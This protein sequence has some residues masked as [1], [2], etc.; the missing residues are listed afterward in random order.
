MRYIVFYFSIIWMVVTASLSRAQLDFTNY[1]P[2]VSEGKIPLDFS[3]E[4]YKKIKQELSAGKDNL[5][6]REAEAFLKEIHY[7]VYH[8]LH[9][10]RVIYG[11]T[12]SR[13]IQAIANHLLQDNDSLRNKLRF[14]TLKASEANAFSTE[15]GIIF[16]TTGL[17]S[18][19]VNEAQ[20]AFVLAHEI[21]H[22]TENHSVEFYQYKLEHKK[23]RLAVK[24]FCNYSKENELEA[25][26]LGMEMYQAAGYTQ[27]ELLG[28]L[29]VLTYSYLP[30]DEV[31]V[32][33]TYFN[34]TYL[35]I[36]ISRFP[37]KKFDI[38]AIEDDNDTRS[39]HPNVKKRKEQLLEEM[40]LDSVWRNNLTFFGETRFSEVQ[41]IC[42]FETVRV[43]LLEN[44]NVDALYSIFLLEK[45][46]P[47][48]V[49]LQHMKAQVWL[50][51]LGRSMNGYSVD[52]LKDDFGYEESLEGEIAQMYDFFNR[53]PTE[54]L[55]TLGIRELYDFTKKYPGDKLFASVFTLGVKKIAFQDKFVLVNYARKPL[56][57]IRLEQ[58]KL[59]EQ[60]SKP[61]LESKKKSKYERIKNKRNVEKIENYDS[62]KY[63][64]Y[65]IPDIVSDS[66]FKQ[67]YSDF[68][69]E[70]QGKDLSGDEFFGEVSYNEN[71][72]V[73]AQ[74]QT[75]SDLNL[76]IDNAI[77]VEP[78]IVCY[79]ENHSERNY[80][81]VKGEKLN[82]VLCLEALASANMVGFNLSIIDQ[83]S[84]QKKGTSDFND[85]NVLLSF[86]Q[87]DG[88]G[89]YL[90]PVD[91]DQ[92]EDIKLR[93][94]STKIM[95]SYIESKTKYS[96]K[97][98]LTR[99]LIPYRIPFLG[100]NLIS[101][102]DG[103]TSSIMH[104]V[105]IDLEDMRKNINWEY[106]FSGKLTKTKLG[107]IYYNVLSNLKKEK[108]Q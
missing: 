74:K 92:L 18:Q 97:R 79:A 19:I 3:M 71:G 11:D 94:G 88:M 78:V 76:G 44:Q 83:L 9:S 45:E 16:V 68:R 38:K 90:F 4:T 80:D 66:N 75:F 23:E 70:Y 58:A 1:T 48:S 95:Y 28:S 81:F 72:D 107:A 99:L 87:Q 53:L 91:Y 62:T 26:R 96:F 13:Y 2:L 6:K 20:L 63:Y 106:R 30:F 32:P 43:Q 42:R 47:T 46:F 15:Q 17:I 82:Q 84:L 69:D 8:V 25:D 39:S 101:N 52:D 108:G 100:S 35:Q 86:G 89:E 85:K 14:Y 12:V 54:E 59:V 33:K 24:E 5:T 37:I 98:V 104:V 27:S 60:Q 105:V 55:L 93:Y 41:S 64:L 102:L 7:G 103:R 73:E 56:A 57:E 10:G 34:S 40:Q 51:I 49:Y 77:L 31:E 29:D 61:I 21:S 22:F 36:P 67:L 50:G 65:G